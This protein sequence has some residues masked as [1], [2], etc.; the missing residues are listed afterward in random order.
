M[1]LPSNCSLFKLYVVSNGQERSTSCII[2]Q[3]IRYT[4]P[5]CYAACCCLL[6]QHFRQQHRSTYLQTGIW[7]VFTATFVFLVFAP[8][9]L[10]TYF[11]SF[12]FWTPWNTSSI[13]FYC[14]GISIS[15]TIIIIQKNKKS[16]QE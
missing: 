5:A 15:I 11:T 3:Y 2:L 16:S 12:I 1:S 8:S 9:F 10:W 14:A 6:C 13:F 7:R 4:V